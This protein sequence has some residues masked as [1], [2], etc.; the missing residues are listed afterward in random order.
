MLLGAGVDADLTPTF[1][2][3]GNVNHLWFENTATLQALRVEGSIPKSMGWDVS[4][5]AIWRP[6]AS[7]NIVLRLSGAVFQPSKGFDDL[8]TQQG[9]DSRFYSVLGNFILAF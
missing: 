1:R 2:I 6:F 8:F 5:A 3:S 9:E 7:Q 4:A